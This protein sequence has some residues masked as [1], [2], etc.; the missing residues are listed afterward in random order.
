MTWP[1][2]CADEY[3]ASPGVAEAIR[4]VNWLS[5]H[6][7]YPEHLEAVLAALEGHPVIPPLAYPFDRAPGEVG[8]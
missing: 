4:W 3:V 1:A 8:A 5:M 2:P 7:G 6:D